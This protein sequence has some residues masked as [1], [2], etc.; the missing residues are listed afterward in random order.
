[1]SADHRSDWP[2][3]YGYTKL[4]RTF[5]YRNVLI[6]VEHRKAVYTYIALLIDC[7]YIFTLAPLSFTIILSLS[8]Y[9][10][11]N[12]FLRNSCRLE[13]Q[14]VRYYS[15]NKAQAFGLPMSW[16]LP[17]VLFTFVLFWF[18]FV[19]MLSLKP[20]P[21][22]QSSFDM[23][24]PLYPQVKFF[25]VSFFSLF[26][27]VAFSGYFLYHYLLPLSLCMESTRTF[28]PRAGFLTSAFYVRIQS[29]NEIILA[30]SP[31]SAGKF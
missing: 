2:P 3:S 20:R 23:Q 25:F 31:V 18:V 16:R 14:P 1:M 7:A 29:I 5:F 10:S 21:F 28:L 24:A 26:G 12:F 8:I 15:I 4:T 30:S 27:D 22:V 6:S 17:L 19:F 11:G 13:G 9:I